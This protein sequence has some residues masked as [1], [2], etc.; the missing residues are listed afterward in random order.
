MERRFQVPVL[1]AALLVIPVIAVQE[2]DADEL[3]SNVAAVANWII[4]LVFL[5]E[6]VAMLAVVPDRRSYLRRHPL[7]VAI[8]VLTPP[9]LPAT[10]QAA[11]TLR[12]L[13]LLRVFKAASVLRRFFSLEGLRWAAIATTFVVIAGGTAFSAVEKDQNLSVWDGLYWA[14]TTVTTIGGDVDPDTT[15]GRIIS[16]VVLL[17]GIGFVAMLT[18]A[19]A[20]QFLGTL[21]TEREEDLSE[22]RRG[23]MAEL[24]QIGTRL[25]RIERGAS[26]EP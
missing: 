2:S 16:V 14:I 24:Q 17:T 4:W 6:L 25:D 13:R 22:M 10:L 19:L 18:G 12:L 1:I 9:F 21:D 7:D 26:R 11:R 20:Q 5:A 8:V 23:L 15:G 3:V